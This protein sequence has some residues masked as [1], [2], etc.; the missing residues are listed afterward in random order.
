M[1]PENRHRSVRYTDVLMTDAREPI[2]RR[3]SSHI[4]AVIVLT[5]LNAAI[6]WR[7]FKTE[8]IDHFNSNEGSA[9]AIARY[10]SSHWGQFSWWPL[11]H[12]GMPYQD[13]R[14]SAAPGCSSVR[15]IGAHP[16][17]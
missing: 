3:T 6:C 4:A 12:C 10:M 13:I 7:L 16:G 5:A 14:S 15:D 9:I 17:G 11:W 8:Y 1:S 2:S